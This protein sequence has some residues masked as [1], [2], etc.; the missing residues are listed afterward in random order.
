MIPIPRVSARE[1]RG[2]G[3]IRNMKLRNVRRKCEVPIEEC[4]RIIQ[5]FISGISIENMVR[6]TGLH[7][8]RI[9]EILLVTRELLLR[10][11]EAG[12]RSLVPR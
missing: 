10:D 5:M 2:A 3:R 12:R 11:H 4:R 8:S 6:V 9:V 1:R 7:K